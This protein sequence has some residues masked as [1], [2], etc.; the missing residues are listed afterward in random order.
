MS[1]FHD[2]LANTLSGSGTAVDRRQHYAYTLY[3]TLTPNEIEAAYRTSWLARKVVDVPVGDMTRSGIDVQLEGDEITRFEAAAKRLNLAPKLK[4]A[5]TLG[6]LGGGA[7]FMGLPG[8]V[9]QPATSNKLSYL[10]VT[11]RW[12]ITTGP[13]ILDL[14]N[15]NF[16]EPEYY[17]LTG[18]SGT[19][20]VHPSRVVPFRGALVPNLYGVNDEQTFWGDSV[21]QATYEAI[22]N[23]DMAQSEIASLIAEAKVDVWKIAQLAETLMGN[24]GEARIRRRFETINTG[25]SIH[26]AAIM[27]AEDDWEQRQITWA[28]IPDVIA[29]YLALVAGAADIPA[30]R[31]LGKAPDG[32]NATGEGD[33]ANY[34]QH[35]AALQTEYLDPAYARIMP[36]IAAEIRVSDIPYTHAPL[37]IP[38]EGELADLAKKKADTSKIYHDMG[39]MPEAEFA[40]AI[41]NQLVEDGTYPG[42]GEALADMPDDWA[43]QMVEE[44]RAR[45]ETMQ[46]QNAVTDAAPR[47]LYVCRKL[48]NA[49]DLQS[50]AAD[51]GL[52]QLQDDLHVT[53]AYS[54]QP[55]DWMK[56]EGD[57]NEAEDGGIVVRPGGVR[58]VEPL[59]SYNAVLLFSSSHLSWRHE[60]ILRAGASYDYPDYQPHV[61]LVKDKSVDLANVEP[62]RGELRFGPEIFEELR[63]D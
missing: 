2:G 37:S 51:Q 42:L 14:S 22:R 3:Q 33:L 12:A 58:I 6:R 34:H 23:A 59:G 56:V 9:D 53:I 46:A 16:G 49:D 24:D 41:V 26:R 45:A 18:K 63:D 62:Y 19:V 21:L 10:H 4:Y 55:L 54:R 1:I 32:M 31:L 28:G 13:L 57:W 43:E 5:L 35:V 50:W 60:Q 17:Y 27:D 38:T 7:M 15:P 52:G 30:T 40:K 39:V 25:K 20:K 8:A 11:S 61:S 29:Q 44:A 48:L 47:T 36:N